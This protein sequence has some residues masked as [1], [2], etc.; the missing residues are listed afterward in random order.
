MELQSA[1]SLFGSVLHKAGLLELAF[2]PFFVK[3]N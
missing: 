1:R 2:S 3:N